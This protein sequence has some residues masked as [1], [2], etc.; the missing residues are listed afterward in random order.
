MG[1]L[2]KSAKFMFELVLLVGDA[3]GMPNGSTLFP[4]ELFELGAAKLPKSTKNPEEVSSGVNV[5]GAG[6]ICNNS[7]RQ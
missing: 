5:F 6:G 3:D 4:E 2:S 1:L 7:Q